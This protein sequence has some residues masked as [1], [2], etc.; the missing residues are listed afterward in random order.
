VQYLGGMIAGDPMK[1]YQSS[2][3][4]GQQVDT[5]D[6]EAAGDAAFGRALQ[7]L[8]SPGPPGAQP[9]PTVPPGQASQ[10][11]G[12]PMGGMT[13]GQPPMGGPPPGGMPPS[14]PGGPQMPPGAMPPRPPMPMPGGPMGAPGGV[15]PQPQGP[16]M[17]GGPPGMPPMGG[18]P[19][20]QG[21]GQPG[22]GIGWQQAVQA[23]VKANPGI[24]Q[25]PRALARAVDHFMPIMNQQS[26]AQW[27]EMQ[28]QLR[29]AA[30]DVREETARMYEQGRN[31]R[32]EAGIES[33]EGI[34]GR[35][36]EGRSER[37]GAAETGRER[38]SERA[39]G[40]RESR[41]ERREARLQNKAD[42]DREFKTKSL[43]LAERRFA[44]TQNKQERD[45]AYRE[46]KAKLDAQ[47]RELHARISAVAA[48]ATTDKQTKELE[49]SYAAAV[50]A[51]EASFMGK[52]TN[53]DMKTGPGTLQAYP[54]PPDRKNDPDG[55]TYN[56]GQYKKQGDQ[57]V[58]VQ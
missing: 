14:M 49:A 8:Y 55:T 46:E 47:Y 18:G 27:R 5:G 24:E 48:G 17:G 33:R 43:D 26:L 3:L 56:N 52:K 30:L 37:A 36:E 20:S 25:N 10:P 41:F 31:R 40:G 32:A 45:A 13:P 51:L 58:P 1:G 4:R 53:R 39:E 12:P 44:Q 16:P 9:M 34:A 57:I 28:L 19:P 50:K 15:P 38:R 2:R 22:G 21:F 54:V 29:G 11:Q 23:V 7:Q 6:A 35:A 42:F